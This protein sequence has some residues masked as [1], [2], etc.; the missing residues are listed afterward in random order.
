MTTLTRKQSATKTEAPER[1]VRAAP[2]EEKPRNVVITAPKFEGASIPIVGSTP[3]VLHKFS[4][5][6]VGIMRAAQEAGSQAR[7]GKAREAR[8]FED[9]YNG[10]RHISRDGWDGIPAAAFRD[11][12]I[13]ACRAIGFKMTLAKMSIVVVADGFDEQGTGL[14]RITHGEPHMDVR[15]ARNSNGG[16]DLRARPMWEPGW[17]AVVTVKWD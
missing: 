6:G 12:M 3:L 1:L 14:V 4:A 5:K 7:K 17:R 13:S 15:H 10:A 16:T 9:N 11:A 2:G 8:V